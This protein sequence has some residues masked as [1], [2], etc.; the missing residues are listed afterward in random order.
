MSGSKRLVPLLVCVS[1][2]LLEVPLADAALKPRPKVE[3]KIATIAPE[4]S[5]WMRIMD[6]LDDEIRSQTGGEVGLKFYP[7]GI[8]GDEGVVLRKIR[9]GQLQGGGFSGTGLGEIAP[10]L[11]VMEIPFAYRSLDEVHAVRERLSPLFEKMLND[12]G[13]QLLGWSDVGFVYLFSKSPISGV[14][15]LR[16]SKMWLWEG[17]PLAK[18]LLQAVGV[19]PVPLPITDV[20]TALQTGMVD[21]VYTSPLA[22]I[23]LQWYARVSDMTDIPV[24]HAMGAVVV[25]SE[26]WNKISP[27]S[28]EIVRQLARKYFTQLDEATAKDNQQSIQVLQQKGIKLVPM[29]AAY[30]AQFEEIGRSVREKLVGTL[31]TQDVLDQALRTL[32][33]VR[34]GSGAK[35]R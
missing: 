16:K 18:T 25:S 29:E 30:R 24:T 12:A 23:S 28:Q 27:G 10:G 4:G 13:F 35:G 34:E 1:L 8:Q 15:D 7:G 17:D 22:C 5:T 2:G 9:A 6:L 26:T 33:E 21:A 14:D 3:I 32:A 11:R 31:Y 19:S 20:V